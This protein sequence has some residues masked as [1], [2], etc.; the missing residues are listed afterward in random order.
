MVTHGPVRFWLASLAA[1]ICSGTALADNYIDVDVGIVYS[2]V[3]PSEPSPVDGDFNSGEAGFHIGVGA[4]RNKMDS[5]WVY[6]V[7]LEVQEVVGH[8]LF[9]LRAI[10]VGYRFT[11]QFTL[12][13]FLGA[14]RYDLTTAA[15]GFRAGLGGR[16]WFSDRWALAADFVF[17]DALARDKLLPEE[18]PD[19]GSPDIFYDV[20]QLSVYLKFKF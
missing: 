16:F 1:G 4:Y 20:L 13:G 2:D 10:D 9:S 6:G 18:N 11:P 12:N 19:V 17:G 7:K 8:T 14:A 5:P 3:S 15:T